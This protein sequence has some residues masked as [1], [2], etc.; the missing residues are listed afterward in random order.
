[1]IKKISSLL[2]LLSMLTL[3]VIPMATAAPF[4][5]NFSTIEPQ[6]ENTEDSYQDVFIITG[7]YSPLEGQDFYVT[8]SLAGDKRLN[9]NGTNGASGAEV[10][11]GMV[12]APSKYAFGTNMHIPGIGYVRVEDRGGAILQAG[13]RGLTHDRLDIWFGPGEEGLRRALAWGKR[14]V[15]VTVY[16]SSADISEQVYFDQ[17]NSVET[18]VQSITSPTLTFPKDIYYGT[19]GE[20]VEKLQGYLKDWGYFE[21][22]ISGFYGADTAQAVLDF[23][24]DY[25]I[26]SGPHELGSGHTGPNTRKKIDEIIENGHNEEAIK[27]QKGRTLLSEHED[28]AETQT[29]FE[30]ALSFGDS[31][32]DVTRLQEELAQLGFLRIDPALYGTFDEVTLNAVF[33]FQQNQGLIESRD[34]RGAGHVGP[35]TRNA[36]NAIVGNRVNIKSLIAYQREALESG[37]H[38][39]NMPEQYDAI[40]KED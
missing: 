3:A 7:Y 17:F 36:L 34:D 22:E 5:E 19:E 37:E 6:P 9:G 12:A 16:G 11:P 24:M 38:S 26:V 33:K 32:S 4:D 23:Q 28:L 13:E 35:A 31:G 39:L 10:F 21:A 25:Q 29:V 14:E 15:L 27:L 20:E 8:G 40:R 2:V 30:R 1:M 18:Y